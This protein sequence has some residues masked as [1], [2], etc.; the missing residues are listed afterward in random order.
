MSESLVELADRMFVGPVW[1]ASIL[2]CLMVGYTLLALIGLIDLGFDPP[3][4]DLD[5]GLDIDVSIDGVG[6]DAA[7]LDAA[8]GADV[9]VDFLHGL[10]AGSIRATN[11]GR[12]PLVLWGG[13]FTVAFWSVS[14]GLWHTIESGL[15]S[16]PGWFLSSLLS[17]PNVVIAVA[18]TKGVT[19]PMLKHFVP[20]PKYGHEKLL[21]ATC[22]ICTIEATGEFGQ[23]KFRTDA[24][25]LLL[26]VRTDGPHIPKGTEVRIIGFDRDKR[27]YK[28][29][30]LQ[31]E[32]TS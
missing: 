30:H 3:D 22:E 10:G 6:L 15:F 23:A 31:Q 4:L 5:P 14:Y 25:P 24:A 11:F 1:P 9:G 21:G 28:V 26:N 8:G 13:V 7:G 18:V 2:V 17:L 12:V 32:T 27:I 19:Q 16:P 20:P 29:T